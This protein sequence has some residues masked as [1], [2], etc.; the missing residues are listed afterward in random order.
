MPDM[1]DW[2]KTHF[3]LQHHFPTLQARPTSFKATEA[4]K[5]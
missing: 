5:K 3:D 4:I 1:Y 2:R